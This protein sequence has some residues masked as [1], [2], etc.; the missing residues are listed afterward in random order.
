MRI[1]FDLGSFRANILDII[2]YF[3]VY[4][5]ADLLWIYV[6]QCSEH[7]INRIDGTF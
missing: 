2:K 4:L 5:H 1:V 7:S 6:A 3:D